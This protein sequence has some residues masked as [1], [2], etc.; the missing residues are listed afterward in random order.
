MGLGEGIGKGIYP[1][2]VVGAVGS[3][4]DFGA[5]IMFSSLG[6]VGCVGVVA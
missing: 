5:E 3:G 1:I 6:V 4:S 2:G